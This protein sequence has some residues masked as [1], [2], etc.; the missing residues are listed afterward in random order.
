M[1]VRLVLLPT[2]KSLKFSP[3]IVAR[4]LDTFQCGFVALAFGLIEAIPVAE[5]N[6]SD[7]NTNAAISRPSTLIC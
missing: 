3:L 6:D 5:V 2:L 4:R 7:D 1:N